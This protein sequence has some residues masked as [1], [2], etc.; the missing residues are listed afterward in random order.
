MNHITP[1][2]TSAPAPA[3]ARLCR[4]LDA[5]FD[6]CDAAADPASRAA[7]ASIVRAALAEAAADPALL[8]PAHREGHADSYCRHLLAAD[9][10]GRY[11]LAALVWQPG[12][13]S[14][15]HTHHTWCGYAVVAGTLAETV[16]AWDAD[17]HRAI[18]TRTRLRSAGAVSFTRA[19]HT[20][21]HRLGNPANV[22][23]DVNAAPAVS[24]HLYG[25]CGTRIATH[26]ND[27]VRIAG[28]SVAMRG[29]TQTES[30]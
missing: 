28:A 9:P 17:A 20:G 8:S 21:I 10:H 30:A 29:T 4:A 3:V 15:V 11:A 6:D 13:A 5:A 12:Q 7:F 18:E 26:V 2:S 16:Y 1:P 22:D 14:P 27:I 23:T 24:L 25:V 19:G